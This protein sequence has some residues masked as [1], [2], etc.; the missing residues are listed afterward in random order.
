VVAQACHGSDA[1]VAG[2]SG[3]VGGGTVLHWRNCDTLDESNW[4][5]GAL[6]IET[7]IDHA[8]NHVFGKV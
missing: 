3:E 2:P 5:R 8:V 1:D 6:T 7:R 4:A